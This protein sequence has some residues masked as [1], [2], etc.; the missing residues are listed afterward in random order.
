MSSVPVFER[1]EFWNDQLYAME[2]PY[3]LLNGLIRGQVLPHIIDTIKG[4]MQ[5]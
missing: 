1:V 4:E 3:R 5:Y 2:L